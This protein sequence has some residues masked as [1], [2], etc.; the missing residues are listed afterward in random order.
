MLGRHRLAARALLFAAVLGLVAWIVLESRDHPDSTKIDPLEPAAAAVAPTSTPASALA[1]ALEHAFEQEAGS[2]VTRTALSATTAEPAH[3]L[4]LFVVDGEGELPAAEASVHW[5][6][7]RELP[8]DWRP[9]SAAFAST[10]AMMARRHPVARCDARGEVELETTGQTVLVLARLEDRWGFEQLS[11]LGSDERVKVTLRGERDVSF[12]VVDENQRP[13]CGV[14]LSL[15]FLRGPDDAWELW[16]GFTSSPE[17]LAVLHG[18]DHSFGRIVGG[19]RMRVVAVIPSFQRPSAE[20]T[21]RDLPAAP[22]RLTLPTCGSLA[23]SALD[24]FGKPL[25]ER[26]QARLGWRADPGDSWHP[27]PRETF[28]GTQQSFAN[29]LCVLPF[30]ETG[31]EFSITARA[32]DAHRPLMVSARGPTVGGERAQVE[33]RFA[34]RWPVLTGRILLDGQPFVRGAI[35]A[36]GS[37]RIGAAILGENA[38]LTTDGAGRFAYVAAP[39][40]SSARLESLEVV[41]L[42]EAQKELGRALVPAPEDNAQGTHELGDIRL[43]LGQLLCSGDVVDEL[44]WPVA[45]AHVLASWPAST[46][47]DPDNPAPMQN[48]RTLSTLTES[49]GSFVLSNSSGASRLRV[50]VSKPGYLPHDPEAVE[51]GARDLRIVLAR[52]G[53]VSGRIVVD[54]GVD[55]ARLAVHFE[56]PPQSTGAGTASFALIQYP[57]ADGRFEL[58]TIQ[59]GRY[60]VS[61]YLQ[62]RAE[63]LATVDGVLVRG[64]ERCPDPRLAQIDL[65]G[66][67]A[68]FEIEIVDE[69]S[70]AIDGARLFSIG[71]ESPTAVPC[72]TEKGRARVL[73]PR[74]EVF[75]AAR[76]FRTTRLD[77]PRGKLRVVLE[78][79]PRV[80]F[81]LPRD[82]RLPAAPIFLNARLFFAGEH[83]PA[84]DETPHDRALRA[85]EHAITMNEFLISPLQFD[86]S[87]EIVF[88]ITRPG[89]YVLTVWF[90]DSSQAPRQPAGTTESSQRIELRAE[91]GE[92]SIDLALDR[93]WFNAM[94]EILAR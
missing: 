52:S 20:F 1:P 66:M 5:I 7:R 54:E 19:G 36:Q 48:D 21:L 25:S 63:C 58:G 23:I 16:S 59:P 17:G 40:Q 53:F 33:L 15:S 35:R 9:T 79:A 42:D 8:D 74:G 88:T 57:K 34:E 73:V 84:P 89:P 60:S 78:R 43:A 47:I 69:D 90:T 61:V 45:G 46:T 39:S 75:V 14:Q 18:V 51:C 24:E 64:G 28:L 81:R 13:A 77:D 83:P 11:G 3:S 87:G 76:G 50:M 91:P 72:P 2:E 44:G 32:E 29:G 38:S 65:R 4:H 85:M 70:H 80:R 31:L 37:Y 6:S 67:L 82:L 92:E 71:A 94:R 56:A 68:A 30:V 10:A 55:A 86:A 49:N 22:L 93:T 27:T 26:V 41:G 12:Q 62:G